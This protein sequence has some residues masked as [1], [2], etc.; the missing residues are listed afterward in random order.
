[1]G[2]RPLP[3]DRVRA[4]GDPAA[5]ARTLPRPARGDGE[6]PRDALLSGQL[7]E[8]GSERA[9]SA[10]DASARVARAVRRHPGGAAAAADAAAGAERAEGVER[11]LRARAD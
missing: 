4:R 7:D 10:G 6:E 3:A 11:E 5:R 1:Q 2:R 9:A 8:R